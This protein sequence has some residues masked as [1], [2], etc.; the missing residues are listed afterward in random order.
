MRNTVA[1]FHWPLIWVGAPPAGWPGL[2]IDAKTFGDTMYQTT[3]K[4]G[5]NVKACRDGMFAFDFSE[6]APGAAP[7]EEDGR[8]IDFDLAASVVLRRTAVLNTHLAC[9]YTAVARRQNFA[10][11]KM[12]VSP[13]DLLHSASLDWD[14]PGGGIGGGGDP[15]GMALLMARLPATYAAPPIADWRVGHRAITVEASTVE[16]S[17]QRLDELLAHPAPH[18]LL[19]VELSL[20]SCKA[21]EDHN[22]SLAMVTAWV[23]VEK[24]LYVHWERYIDQNRRRNIGDVQ[25]PFI[26]A[27]RKEKLTES[28]EFTASVVSEILSLVDNIPLD[29][30]RDISAVRRVRNGWMHELRPVTR[31]E[32]ELA[33][34]VAERM[35]GFVERIELAMPPVATLHM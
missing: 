1:Y 33:L 14:K 8:P 34:R 19:A 31:L 16:E 24:L 5:I 23:V 32:G 12:V 21:Y 10:L 11:P 22:Y 25:A 26:N 13:S 17:F 3:L 35:L 9:L 7:P 15:R 4:A 28:S 20:R 6:W 30:Y 27:E 18:A 29:L 2:D